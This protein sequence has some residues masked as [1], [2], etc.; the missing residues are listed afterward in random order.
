MQIKLNRPLIFIDLEAT[1]LNVG[2][3]R[4]VEISLIKLFPDQRTEI[5]TERI[6]PGIPIPEVVSRIHGIRDADVAQK[7]AFKD[8]ASSLVRF[9][10]NSDLSGYNCNKFDVPMLAEEFLRAEVDFELEGRKVVDVQNIF[11]FMEPRTLSAA[12]KF[13][14]G[15]TLD[16]AHS[17]EGDAMATFEILQ[18]QLDKYA[19]SFVEDEKGNTYQPV[20]NDIGKLSELSTRTKNVD[21]AGRIIYNEKGEEVFSFG[22]HKDK[23][24]VEIFTREPSYYSWIMNG[25]F[26]LYTKKVVTRIRLR[27]LSQKAEV[28]GQK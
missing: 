8:I 25:D 10:D 22:K 12:Y 27:M 24:V 20:V 2:S 3:D 1:G 5:R 14:C 16:A 23:S 21:L 28:K 26:P 19:Q 7:P 17:A 6:N 4:I 15:K 9:I 11:H 13:Y 18:M